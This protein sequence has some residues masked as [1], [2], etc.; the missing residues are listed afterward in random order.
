MTVA[1]LIHGIHVTT[2]FT[3]NIHIYYK[4][5]KHKITIKLHNKYLISYTSILSKSII[6]RSDLDLHLDF[7]IFNASTISKPEKDEEGLGGGRC[8]EQAWRTNFMYNG[9]SGILS[10]SR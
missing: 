1:H 5:D 7:I 4:Q 8:D 10:T 3:I 2:I 9:L 6:I